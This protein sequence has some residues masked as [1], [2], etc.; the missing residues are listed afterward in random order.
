MGKRRRLALAVVVALGGTGIVVSVLAPGGPAVRRDGPLV[1]LDPA[2]QSRGIPADAGEALTF[3]QIL[4]LNEGRESVTLEDVVAVEPDGEIAIVG[5]LVGPVPRE[6]GLIVYFP[7]FP[8]TP[9][10]EDLARGYVLPPLKP[11]AG[12]VLSTRARGEE[13]LAAATQLFIGIESREPEGEADI[14]SFLVRYRVGEV[15]YELLIPFLVRLCTPY[16]RWQEGRT[17][18]LTPLPGDQ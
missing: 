17:R 2:R 10:D 9:D 7:T 1:S 4:L 12:Y 15:R 13:K 16:S 5:L 18:C 6:S 8:P 11:V 3:A 14:E